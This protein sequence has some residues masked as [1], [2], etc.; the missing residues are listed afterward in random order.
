MFIRQLVQV[1]NNKRCKFLALSGWN[2]PVPSEFQLQMAS[3]AI[4]ISKLRHH[5]DILATDLKIDSFSWETS[6]SKGPISFSFFH[7]QL[8]YDGNFVAFYFPTIQSQEMN[9]HA[10]T[11][12]MLWH[13]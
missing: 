6:A 7:L 11:A 13:V 3:N 4:S 12:Q 5:H 2:P 9:E 10:T 8:I 1:N